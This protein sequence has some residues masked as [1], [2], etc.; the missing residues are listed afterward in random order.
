MRRL[1]GIMC[2]L[3]ISTLI[4]FGQI[5][6]VPIEAQ[7]VRDLYSSLKKSVSTSWIRENPVLS[8]TKPSFFNSDNQEHYFVGLLQISGHSFPFTRDHT[9]SA[10]QFLLALD[11]G[12]NIKQ[13]SDADKVLKGT[14]LSWNQKAYGLLWFDDAIHKAEVGNWHLFEMTECPGTIVFPLLMFKKVKDVPNALTNNIQGLTIFPYDGR[15]TKIISSETHIATS[16]GQKIKGVGYD[17][18][19][20]NIFDIFTYDEDIDDTT[21]YNRLYINVCGH[22]ECR[23]I[24]LDEVCV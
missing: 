22:W 9:F 17:V 21:S 11:S 6:G 12:I 13:G 7:A 15:I 5:R 14:R 2:G 1:I 8:E 19:N 16:D 23:W 4:S 24:R 20:D 10:L 18:N 3:I